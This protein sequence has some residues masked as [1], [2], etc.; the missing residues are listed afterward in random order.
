MSSRRGL[1]LL[2][3]LIGATALMQ[4]GALS[5]LWPRPLAFEPIA[6]APGFRKLVRDGSQVTAGAIDPFIGLSS[7][8]EIPPIPSEDLKSEL[9]RGSEKIA[10]FSDYNCPLC[11]AQERLLRQAEITYTLHLLPLLGPTSVLG[12]RASIAAQAQGA[13]TQMHNKLMTPLVVIDEKLIGQFAIE[14][15]LDETR[16]L[17][18]MF[19]SEVTD[20]IAKTKGL[21]E[22][23][24]VIGTP[25]M[26][27][28]DVF[29]SGV[30]ETSDVEAILEIAEA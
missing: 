3:G 20:T 8:D 5:R 17:N 15:G 4:S 18:D 26:V 24:A 11:V 22:A 23:F 21:A 13:A 29:V 28:G 19:K 6:T 2:G 16:L 10:V 7:P 9:F 12:A 1:L 30:I 27:I 14:L 25:S